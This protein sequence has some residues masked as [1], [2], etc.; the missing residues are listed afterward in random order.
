MVVM[1]SIDG[2]TSVPLKV[3]QDRIRCKEDKKRNQDL[4]PNEKK[5]HDKK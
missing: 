4:K 1:I 2:K 3:L 5:E